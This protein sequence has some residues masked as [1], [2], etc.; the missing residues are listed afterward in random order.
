MPKPIVLT[1]DDFADH[2][3][4]RGHAGFVLVLAHTNL[5][6]EKAAAPDKHS[7]EWEQ[8]TDFLQMALRATEE[9][10]EVQ[11]ALFNSRDYEFMARRLGVLFS[12][13]TFECWAQVFCEGRYMMHETAGQCDETADTFRTWLLGILFHRNYRKPQSV[14]EALIWLAYNL[15]EHRLDPVR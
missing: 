10:P 4:L 12:Y 9:F 2:E 1:E 8:A 15:C 5:L 13:S 7:W 14:D 3:H 11:V 6:D